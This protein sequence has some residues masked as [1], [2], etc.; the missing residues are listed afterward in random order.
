MN[1][2]INDLSFE[3]AFSSK[4]EAMEMVHQW[5]NIC[6]KI[7][8]GEITVVEKLCSEIINTSA[9]IAPGVP[10]IQLVKEFQ[11]SDERRYLIHLLANLEQPECKPEEPFLFGENQ[12]YICAWA[13][14]GI[15]ISLETKGVFKEP[16]LKGII[17]LNKVSIKNISRQE[18][19]CLYGKWLGIRHYEANRKHRKIP[20]IDAAG[21][22]VAAMDLSE[23]DAQKLLNQ[24]IEINGNLY[25]KKHGQYY[26][27]QNHHDN[28]YHGYQNND[29][30]ENIIKKIDEKNWCKYR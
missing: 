3:S 5:M 11:T 13:K 28:C 25:G 20:Y 24:A 21:R 16:E 8:S 19:I 6:K 9:E 27:F 12:S 1:A 14:D 22:H 29:L 10:L 4:E 26:S 15:L 30:G 17:G 23:L 2:A 18:H 7:E